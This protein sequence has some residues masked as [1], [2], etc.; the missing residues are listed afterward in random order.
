MKKN[1]TITIDQKDVEAR[2]LTSS[3]GLTIDALAYA[4]G[5]W[6]SNDLYENN[7]DYA[8]REPYNFDY[9]T[10]LLENT[11]TAED[12]NTR[13]GT[14]CSPY[15]MIN[16]K[17]EDLKGLQAGAYCALNDPE[18]W[19]KLLSDWTEK[20][21]EEGT[22]GPSKAFNKELQAA[23][24]SYNDDQHREW[25]NG[26]HRNWPGIV[27]SVSKYF[28]EDREAGNYDQKLDE[29][30]FTQPADVW[31][32][33]ACNCYEEG[34]TDYTTAEQVKAWILDSIAS[35]GATRANKDRAAREIR[36]AEYAKTKAYKEAGARAVAEARKKKLEALTL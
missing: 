36:S 24:D 32:E 18:A 8:P 22:E 11:V 25:L 26:D 34:C 16:Y 10:D 19:S 23:Q 35:S 13:A 9:E 1:I 3:S 6:D 2:K 30:T 20:L 31:H 12:F 15:M 17:A 21:K 4:A 14:L 28:T 5:Q 7:W 33:L 27:E 29:Y